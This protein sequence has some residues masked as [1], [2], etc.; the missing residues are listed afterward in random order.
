MGKIMS[1]GRYYVKDQA[2]GRVFCVEPISERNEKTTGKVFINGG[3][4]GNAEKNK[5]NPLGGSIHEEDSIITT[6]NGFT[7]ITTL[8]AGTSPNS[9]IEYLCRTGKKVGE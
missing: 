2:T 8:P 5:S 1:T 7:D 6:D 9:Y 3:F 4:D